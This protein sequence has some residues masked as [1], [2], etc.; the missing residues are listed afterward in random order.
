[1][2]ALTPTQWEALRKEYE[3]GVPGR[4][5]ARAYKVNEGVIRKRA[6]RDTWGVNSKAAAQL[7]ATAERA[8]LEGAVA[9][10]L[11]VR[12]RKGVAR[13]QGAQG[14]QG[15]AEGTQG[16]RSDSFARGESL[17]G[18]LVADFQEARQAIG[19]AVITA[20]AEVVARANMQTLGNADRMQSLF[21]RQAG[22]L[23]VV[24]SSPDPTD[25]GAVVA[26][27]DAV[28]LLLSGR[29]TI[30]GHLAAASRLMLDIQTATR[31][32]L[33]VDDKQ[34]LEISTPGGRGQSAAGSEAA[35]LVPILAKMSTEQ[36][37][38]IW[39]VSRMLQG[40]LE[41]PPIPVPPGDPGDDAAY[42]PQP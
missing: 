28:N 11:A 42:F 17:R 10:Q 39:R 4:A 36:L 14:T 8:T 35:A 23:E 38:D 13:T 25:A 40:N 30:A 9:R 18:A 5:L 21:D 27:A 16:G 22:L 6:K 20:R 37:A 3:A 1:M 26:R 24:L 32:A 29:E 33:G 34:K 41:R 15:D 19:D 31:K 12:P 7:H 2:A